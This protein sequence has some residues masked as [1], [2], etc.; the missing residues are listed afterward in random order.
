MGVYRNG[1]P[2][3]DWTPEREADLKRMHRNRLSAAQCA[4]FFGCG[5]TR[6]AVIGKLYRLGL[7][8]DDG[9]A[10]RMPSRAM[11]VPKP[12]RPP[13][14]RAE[15]PP[16]L[17]KAPM[18]KPK[19]TDVARVSILELT[20]FTCRWPVGNPATEG[21]G[22]CGLP[23]GDLQGGRPYCPDHAAIATNKIERRPAKTRAQYDPPFQVPADKETKHGTW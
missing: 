9:G 17:P 3:F 20:N 1:R 4:L 6:N 14:V 18:P 11:R 21:F 10:A 13:R 8:S 5:C 19:I 16:R 15:A 2:Y 23:Q 7:T 22:Y 12:P